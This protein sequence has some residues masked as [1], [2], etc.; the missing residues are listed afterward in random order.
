MQNKS[1]IDNLRLFISIELN[2]EAINYANEVVKILS[3]NQFKEVRWVKPQNLHLTLK[4]LGD[5]NKDLIPDIDTVI[6][7]AIQKIS[8]FQLELRNSGCFP[9][10]GRSRILRID[11]QGNIDPLVELKKCLE[12]HLQTVGFAPDHHNFS[13]HITVGRLN[14]NFGLKPGQNIEKII[15]ET[16][17]HKSVKMPVKYIRLMESKLTQSGVIYRTIFLYEL[18]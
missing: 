16:M 3:Q 8:P 14:S 7:S 6:H 1:Y 5:T 4:F 9:N 10:T 13:P 12:T 11:F 2:H 18:K 15:S 17:L